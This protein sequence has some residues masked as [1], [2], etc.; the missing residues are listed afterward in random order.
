MINSNLKRNLTLL[1][2]IT[3]VILSCNASKI[4]V[5]ENRIKILQSLYQNKLQDFLHKLVTEDLLT[6]DFKT[7]ESISK[8][9]LV[10][11]VI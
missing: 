3:S 7:R 10:L 4:K 8:H 2:Y 6:V 5:E 1:R 9:F 11:A